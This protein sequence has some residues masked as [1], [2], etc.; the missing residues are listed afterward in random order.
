MTRNTDPLGIKL[1]KMVL[2]RIQKC[3]AGFE[4]A[5][6]VIAQDQAECILCGNYKRSD[7][8]LKALEAC[9]YYASTCD[10]AYN[11]CKYIFH[12]EDCNSLKERVS[13]ATI[14]C[15]RWNRE[16]VEFRQKIESIFYEE[17]FDTEKGFV[18]IFWSQSPINFF[19]IGKTNAGLPR[20]KEDKH[21]SLVQSTK[22]ATKLTIIFPYPLPNKDDSINDVEASIRDKTRIDV[23]TALKIPTSTTYIRKPRDKYTLFFRSISFFRKQRILP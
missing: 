21:S 4:K 11:L 16:Y 20:F 17:G 13:I 14:E 23:L 10:A 9:E 6:K 1:G 3:E 2:E 12:N 5:I 7:E 19:Y 8:C 18:Y 15:S 22:E